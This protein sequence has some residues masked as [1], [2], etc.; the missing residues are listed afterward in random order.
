MSDDLNCKFHRVLDETDTDVDVVGIDV[1]NNQQ[2]IRLFF[3]SH[4]E[5]KQ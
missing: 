3:L 2:H 4:K 5:E 1:R